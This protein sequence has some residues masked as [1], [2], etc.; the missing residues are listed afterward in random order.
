MQ[1]T[2]YKMFPVRIEWGLANELDQFLRDTK[3]TK[4]EFTKT[5]IT[6]MLNEFNKS[7]VRQSIKEIYTI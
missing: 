4:T 1:S 2:K 3:T 5:A 7:G 6:K